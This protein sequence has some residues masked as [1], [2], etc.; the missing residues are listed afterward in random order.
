VQNS[1]HSFGAKQLSL[2]WRKTAIT[3]LLNWRTTAIT[4]LAQNSYH[5]LAQLAQNSYHSLA[6]L[7][8][9]SDIFQYI[10]HELE[11]CIILFLL[12]FINN[13]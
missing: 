3:H 4:H 2:T 6:R 5:S 9:K 7:F 10:V 13:L 1:Y 12:E 11:F 8:S